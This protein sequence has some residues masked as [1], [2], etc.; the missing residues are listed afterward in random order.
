MQISTYTSNMHGYIDRNLTEKIR[1]R[2]EN[3]PAAAILGPR[4]CGK[5]TLAHRLAQEFPHAVYLDLE[6]P[7]DLAKLTDPE[8]FFT[9]NKGRLCC[10]DEIQRKPEIFPVLRSMIDANGTNG[11][12][13]IL[14]SAS[15]DLI[16]QSSET[17]AGRI[18][19]AELTP[20]LLSELPTG[21]TEP[22]R[23]LWLKGGYPR[24]YLAKSSEI[25]CNWREDFI[26]TFF[27]REIPL[28]GFKY[29]PSVLERFW[30]FCGHVHGQL[31]NLSK[32]G[33]SL[34]VNYHTIKNYTELLER[35]FMLRLLKPYSANLKKR[36]VKSPKLYVR[37]SGLLHSLLSISSQNDL[38]GHPV[39]G[40]S[41]EG[42][43]MEN[44]LS[45]LPE[46]EASFYR[47]SNG[48]EID[49]ILQR[50]Q[51]NVAVEFKA[52]SAPQVAR[53]FWD[54]LEQLEIKEAYVVSPVK[55]SYPLK[56]GVHV[57]SLPEFIGSMLKSS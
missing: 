50:G 20:F 57:V 34:G 42:F 24:S 47:T 12:F 56:K 23:E 45:E 5:S 32:L 15:R 13:L 11:Q 25:S 37:D 29:S 10:L 8:A 44:I 22:L 19:Y 27:E 17:L 7:S 48:A 4:Q 3:F 53:G 33:E 41:W 28:L 30:K 35:T 49:L 26:R 39:Y 55:E 18:S 21:K 40:S 6:K 43:A 16:R 1:T 54:T 9:L 46:W 36:L 38:L 31:L 14:G 51:R 52:H 2:L